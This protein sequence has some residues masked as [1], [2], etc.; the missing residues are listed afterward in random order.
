MQEKKWCSWIRG[1]FLW[2]PAYPV[3]PVLSSHLLLNLSKGLLPVSA[4]VKIFKALLPY[5][6]LATWPAHLIL[7][8]LITL[9]ILGERYKPSS[10]SL[11]NL[12]HSPF[13]SLLD[14]STRLRIVFSNIRSQASQPYS[15]T[16]N[17]M[18]L[19]ILIFKFLEISLD[20]K[21]VWTE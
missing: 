3:S 7:L 2:S 19:Y 9:S 21:S 18:V 17:I 4:P 13:S 11:W 1:H 10:S 14:Q 12:L 6:I 20:D 8:H 15:T 16:G 5:F